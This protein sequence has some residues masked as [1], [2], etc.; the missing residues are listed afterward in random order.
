MNDPRSKITVN[1]EIFKYLIAGGIA[2]ICDFSILIFCSEILELH[3]LLGNLLGYFLG[4]FVAYYLNVKWV[5]SYRKYQRTS[6][7]LLLFNA[8]VLTGLAISE[9]MMAYLVGVAEA[10]YMTAKIAASALVMV[11]NYTAKKIILFSPAIKRR[12]P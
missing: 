8:I 9:G 4:L 2:F 6:V 12:N 1:N 11:F 10:H 7:E 5:F 3:Y